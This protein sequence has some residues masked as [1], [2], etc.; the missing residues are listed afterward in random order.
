[1]CPGR[2]VLHGREPRDGDDFDHGAASSA[3]GDEAHAVP[4]RQRA[5]RAR[6]RTARSP[7]PCRAGAT[8][9]ATRTGRR[10]R[11][12]RRCATR[13]R[14]TRARGVARR[15]RTSR[16]SRPAQVRE[17]RAGSPPRRPRTSAPAWSAT[18]S[19]GR[20][21]DRRRDLVE[22]LAVVAH[23]RHVV[24]E[25]R[26]RRLAGRRCRGCRTVRSMRSRAPSSGAPGANATSACRSVTTASTTSGAAA[27]Q[28]APRGRPR[29]RPASTRLPERRGPATPGHRRSLHRARPAPPAR[30]PPPR[31]SR[32]GRTPCRRRRSRRARCCARRRGRRLE[33]QRARL[34]ARHERPVGAHA[35]VR[36][37]LRAYNAS[38]ARVAAAASAPRAGP[39]NVMPGAERVERAVDQRR[40]DRRS[41]RAA[42]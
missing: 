36:E 9:R 12:G 6:G 22:V 1:M 26:R 14:G 34:P 29:R 13:E 7:R 21:P 31:A 15:G 10:P 11:T 17:A 16:G 35:A 23:A 32:R 38:P 4:E 24:A 27:R 37:P 5:P 3:K 39:R 18:T 33:D 20:Q 2:P 40:R 8:R 41:S 30:S 25:P 42:W 19:R 28:E